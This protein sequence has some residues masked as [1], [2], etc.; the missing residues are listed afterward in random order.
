MRSSVVLFGQAQGQ[1]NA[2]LFEAARSGI[3]RSVAPLVEQGADLNTLW[4]EAQ[5]QGSPKRSKRPNGQT[6]LHVAVRHNRH[7]TVCEL[8]RLGADPNITDNRG[9][10]PMHVAVACGHASC[11]EALLQAGGDPRMRTG[12]RRTVLMVATEYARTR[13]VDRLLGLRRVVSMIHETDDVGQTALVSSA[14]C[15]WPRI[16]IC[17]PMNLPN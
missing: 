14:C 6:P 11:F 9:W 3:V 2:Q 8:L 16:C 15:T 13:M 1:L 5:S 12:R 17:A 4:M 10:S 7:L